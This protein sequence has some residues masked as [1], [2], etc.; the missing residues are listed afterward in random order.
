MPPNQNTSCL[1]LFLAAA[2]FMAG[3]ARALDLTLGKSVQRPG[4]KWSLKSAPQSAAAGSTI[5]IV[6]HGDV[7]DGYYT[8][9]TREYPVGGPVSAPPTFEF[10]PA[11]LLELSGKISYSQPKIKQEK[12][13]DVEV[14]E[15]E[16]TFTLP[17][18]IQPGAA[19]GE[20][21]ITLLVS[22]QVCNAK[23]CVPTFNAKVPLTL[24]ITPAAAS[25][26]PAAD[27]GKPSRPARKAVDWSIPNSPLSGA[28]GETLKVEL[29]GVVPPKWH[30]YPARDQGPTVYRNQARS[31]DEKLFTRAGEIVD[32][33][34]IP[35]EEYG[36]KFDVIEG[37]GTYIVPIR[38]SPD[39]KP[40][41]YNTK[42]LVDSQVCTDVCI[43][44]RDIPVAFT[45]TVT[46]ASPLGDAAAPPDATS[47][48]AG[49]GGTDDI[50]KAK[51]EGLWAY[52]RLA[53]FTGFLALFT[54]C[55]FPMIPITVSFF[56]KRKQATRGAAI[57]DA[58]FYALG[59]ITAFVVL[60]FFFTLLLGASGVRSIATNAWANIFIAGIFTALAF[61]LFGAYEIQVPASIMNA[62]NKKA[63]EGEGVLSVVL[64]GIVFAL[65]SFTCTVPFV[66]A[67]LVTATQGDFFWPAV[68]ML[69]FATVFAAP[70]LVLAMVPAALKKL[71]K[72]GGWLNSVKVVMG[73][74]EL[75]AALKFIS[76]IDIAF[77]WGI[78]T[79][80]VFLAA[81]IAICLMIVFYL[82][83][84]FQMTHDSPVEKIGA[85]R[86]TLATAF[87]CLAI[88]M[89]AG[90][91]G[92]KLGELDA[93]I[94]PRVYPGQT[95]PSFAF[96][97]GG[98][99]AKDEL[100]WI[101][102]YDAALAEAKKSNTPLFMDFTGD[103]CTNCR[104]MEEN[105]FPR[106][107]IENLLKGFVRAKLVTD[108]RNTPANSQRSARYVEMQEKQFGSVALPFYVILAPDGTV[109]ATFDGFTRD[110]AAYEAF[111][112]KGLESKA[113]GSTVTTTR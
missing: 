5:E 84:K 108:R 36:M 3:D 64:M 80:E 34:T 97:A 105:M 6:L 44:S 30:T 112:K 8:Y 48:S 24:T 21:A 99:G 45:L 22:S 17:V 29:H 92:M 110:N 95:E 18:K 2:A 32:P 106:P 31:S 50:A 12:E 46:G 23:T 103:L 47:S 102:D 81:W 54:P 37:Q 63:D 25:P 100:R 104:L 27:N 79:R 9:S 109:R 89:G 19:Q 55:V 15:H 43:E 71:P 86:A 88:W 62:L 38:I 35:H 101:E 65:T 90:I 87:L 69:G 70:F 113:A 1:L 60:G 96:G 107:E 111:L 85:M 26:E 59:I 61:S 94:P 33:P 16:V 7:P 49:Q 20:Q 57:R 52:L 73:F 14:F 56:T 75:A 67:V 68:G 66:G 82:L 42:L 76:N 77:H 83:G 74:L 53:M 51:R 93:F 40:G 91:F 28:R 39:A 72:S 11:G 13:G 78:L 98:G 58:G 4:V 41:V 10:E